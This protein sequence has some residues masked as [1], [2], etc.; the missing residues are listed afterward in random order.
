MRI[1]RAVVMSERDERARQRRRV[2]DVQPRAPVTRVAPRAV[3]APRVKQL[4]VHR[5]EHDADL[6][7]PPCST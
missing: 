1:G 3:A 5:I 4:V 7:T 2:G 6:G